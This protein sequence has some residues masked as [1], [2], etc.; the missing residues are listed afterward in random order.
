MGQD[1]LSA[2]SQV[3]TKCLRTIVGRTGVDISRNPSKNKKKKVGGKGF[4]VA[5][6]SGGESADVHILLLH[7][8]DGGLQVDGLDLT[9]FDGHRLVFTG[10]A[11]RQKTDVI[12][13]T[14]EIE[15]GP[16]PSVLLAETRDLPYR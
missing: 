1:E 14:G 9:I 16:I 10:V 15:S 8:V 5:S 2:I 3:L 13:Q 6:C 12:P 7:R 11:R 4:D